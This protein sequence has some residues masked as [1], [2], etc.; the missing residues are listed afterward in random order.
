M[1]E[2]TCATRLRAVIAASEPR[3][4]AISAD[5]SSRRPAPGKW[6]PREIVGHLID[7]ASNN[8]QRFVR[9]RWQDDLVFQ[10]YAQDEWVALQRYQ[11]TPWDELL[12]LWAA[13]NL[14]IA[15][16][17]AVVPEDV[18]LRPRA[19]HNLDEIAWQVVPRSAPATLDYFMA[20]YVGH[21]EHHLRQV[22]GA[23][24]D[25]PGA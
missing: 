14:H 10:G 21:L 5:A 20:D 3:L 18:R 17:M 2:P 23:D 12:D 11:D 8:H 25:R 16:V 19:R 6:S 4:R 7:S 1:S 22:L 9:A 24:L 15:R 13:F